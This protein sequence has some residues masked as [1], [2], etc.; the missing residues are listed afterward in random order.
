MAMREIWSDATTG[1]SVHVLASTDGSGPAQGMV[2]MRDAHGRNSGL[3]GVPAD[4]VEAFLTALGSALRGQGGE[5][6]VTLP[7]ALARYLSDEAPEEHRGCL[8]PCPWGEL[9]ALVERSAR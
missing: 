2:E 6:T 8:P 4:R 9:H 5:P 7:L 3:V 1:T